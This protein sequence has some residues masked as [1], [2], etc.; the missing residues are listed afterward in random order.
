M[1]VARGT[2]PEN[3][4]QDVRFRTTYYFRVFDY[5]S[6]AGKGGDVTPVSDSLYRFVMTGKAN[7]FA[8]QVKFE[9]GTLQAE[10][11]DP[12]GATIEQDAQTGR[13]YAVPQNIVQA[14][15]RRTETMEEIE[16]LVALKRKLIE[17]N[18][19][20]ASELGVDR[21]VGTQTLDTIESQIQ[22][23]AKNGLS[24]GGL[25]PGGTT[26]KREDGVPDELRKLS[27]CPPGSE[28]QRGFQI[29][30]PQGVKSFDQQERL[31]MAMTT[32]AEP[33]I[34]TLQ[35]TSQRV[36][37]EKADEMSDAELLLPLLRER[38]IA[39]ELKRELLANS[40]PEDVA[41]LIDTLVSNLESEPGSAGEES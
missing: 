22:S 20:E 32:T 1:S 28:V 34:Q 9:S 19:A 38:L 2:D 10:Q 39:S 11:I 30:G 37:N 16:A 5:C 23:L 18:A 15:A 12:F 27:V 33:L 40:D 3:F 14:R 31:I 7:V 6:A 21:I 17:L 4:D 41:A 13:I 8:S 25:V 36:L 29:M 24:G 26:G 35:K